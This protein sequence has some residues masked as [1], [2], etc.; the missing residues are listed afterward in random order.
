MSQPDQNNEDAIRERAYFMW[1]QEGRPEGRGE[2]HWV[3]AAA[4]QIRKEARLAD[5]FRPEDPTPDEERLIDGRH[6]VN[7]PAM[8][9]KDVPG[10]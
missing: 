4:E 5:I 1:V 3:R 8:L 7:F 6:D 9:T 2:E 10:G